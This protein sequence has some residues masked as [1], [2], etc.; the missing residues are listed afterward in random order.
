MVAVLSLCV[1]HVC[2]SNAVRIKFVKP[3]ATVTATMYYPTTGQCDKDPYLTAGLYKI[4]PKRASKQKWIA[5]S[6]DLLKRWGGKSHYGDKVFISGANKKDG[7]YTI[8]DTMNKRYK[9]RMDFLE[10]C[11]TKFYKY[12]DVKIYPYA[13]NHKHKT[14]HGNKK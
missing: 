2:D 1:W 5:L 10:T 12:N 6:R 13:C 7:V 9:K 3:I 8:V 14:K 4:N 11:G